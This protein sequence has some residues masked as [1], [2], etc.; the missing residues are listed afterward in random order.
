LADKTV[1][2]A[3]F[4]SQNEAMREYDKIYL[5]NIARALKIHEV[6]VNVEEYQY[7]EKGVENEIR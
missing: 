2:I 7:N 4:R 3:H 5:S 1:L 6:M